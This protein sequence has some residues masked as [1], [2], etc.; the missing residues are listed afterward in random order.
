MSSLPFLLA[1]SL[2]LDTGT[3]RARE[4][5]VELLVEKTQAVGRVCVVDRNDTLFV[6]F[7][8]TGG[9]Q[10]SETHLAIGSAREEIPLAGGRQPVL[11]R[12]PYKGEHGPG[13]LEFGYPIPVREL[14]PGTGTLVLAA[15]ATVSRPGAE[16]GAWA[17]GTAF[18]PEGSPAS[19]FSVPRPGA[20]PRRPPD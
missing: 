16:E 17:G 18:T 6:R 8:A 5:C 19:Y 3:P 10:L 12:F 20:G 4:Y 14:P 13:V 9:W 11:G 7:M 1:T 2:M 15:H